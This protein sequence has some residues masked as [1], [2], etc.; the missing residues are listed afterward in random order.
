[1]VTGD[2]TSTA[3]SVAHAVDFQTVH[4]ETTP[5]TKVRI[6]QAMRPRPVLMVG[7]GINDAPVLAA[8]DVGV[9]MAGRGATVASESAAAVITSNG[10]ARSGRCGLCLAAHGADRPAVDLDGHHRLRS[11]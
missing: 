11:V 4:A 7:D 2:I 9:A 1:M 6:V 5:Q 8:A 10:I 3:E